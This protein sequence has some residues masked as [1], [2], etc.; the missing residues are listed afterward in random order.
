MKVSYASFNFNQMA[1]RI[2]FSEYFWT[3]YPFFILIIIGL[4]EGVIASKLLK[5]IFFNR[6]I[7][8]IIMIT[9]VAGYF[10]EYYINMYLNRGFIM[11]VW[12]PWMKP[13]EGYALFEYLICFPII[14]AVTCLIES[15][16]NVIAL[17]N[18]YKWSLILK[19]TLL[20]NFISWIILIIA[21]N[22]ITFNL[23]EG[24]KQCLSMEGL[25]TLELPKK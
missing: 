14:F 8:I 20:I 16:I 25:P 24:E 1:W 10:F 3:V 11:L 12:I 9:N 18:R 23:I 5:G 15:L 13:V 7:M 17:K 19:S 22:C 2:I 21:I 6:R 4:F